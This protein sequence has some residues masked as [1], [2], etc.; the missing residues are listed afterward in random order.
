MHIHEFH[1]TRQPP[2]EGGIASGGHR[3]A[4]LSPQLCPCPPQVLCKDAAGNEHLQCTLKD[5]SY[6]GNISHTREVMQTNSVR[7]LTVCCLFCLDRRGFA[8]VVRRHPDLAIVLQRAS[9]DQRAQ[10]RRGRRA[11]VASGDPATDNPPLCPRRGTICGEASL[12]AHA[13]AAEQARQAV[14]QRPTGLRKW[15][16]MYR[17]FVHRLRPTEV[18]SPLRTLM[19]RSRPSEERPLPCTATWLQP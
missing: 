5:G 17:D 11:S 15:T 9:M 7:A 13:L 3:L 19:R 8:R 1:D 12:A 4:G 2:S 6:F 10:M 18:A 16:A 14:G